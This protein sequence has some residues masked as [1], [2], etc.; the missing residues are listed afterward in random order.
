MRTLI[1]IVGIII[2]PSAVCAWL[3]YREGRVC[4]TK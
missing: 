3:S 1:A 4:Q 2:L